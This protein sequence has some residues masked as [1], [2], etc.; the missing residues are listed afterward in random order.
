L[1]YQWVKYV[2]SNASPFSLKLLSGFEFSH[3]GLPIEVSGQKSRALLCV[4]ALNNGKAHLRKYLSELLWEG[5][6]SDQAMTNLRQTL[7]VIK[8]DL[9]PHY[10][11]ALEVTKQTIRLRQDIVAVDALEPALID[12][13]AI[14]DLALFG[15][16][17]A[18]S[19]SFETWLTDQQRNLVKNAMLRTQRAFGQ[20]YELG[21]QS[22][23]LQLALRLH[24]FEPDNEGYGLQAYRLLIAAGDNHKAAAF[25]KDHPDFDFAGMADA[26]P[27]AEK[28]TT[29]EAP[30]ILIGRFNFKPDD[31]AAAHI[32]IAL[33]EAVVGDLAESAWVRV[34]APDLTNL[35]AP[36]FGLVAN[37]PTNIRWNY[38]LDGAIQSDPLT[39]SIW[40]TNGEDQ[41]VVWT[42]KFS[43]KTVGIIADD[44][45]GRVASSLESIVLDAE[46]KRT[47][48][49][50][51]IAG[52]WEDLARARLLFWR[53]SQS[54][55][56]EA[57]TLLAQ[58]L[59]DTPH[60]V[61]VLTLV[62][63]AK[64]MNAWS[65]W[66]GSAGSNLD[67]AARF[68]RRAIQSAPDDAWS[69]MTMGTVLSAR[70]DL[71]GAK[72]KLEQAIAIRPHLAA[73]KG[74][75]ARVLV[76]SGQTKAGAILASEALDASPRDPHASL[77]L[78]SQALAAWMDGHYAHAVDLAELAIEKRSNW[79]PNF[80]IAAAAHVRNGNQNAAEKAI[81]GAMSLGCDTISSDALR[82]GHPF[83]DRLLF[84]QFV[85]NLKAAGWPN[86]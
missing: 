36:M 12:A 6:A 2:Q 42:E 13:L 46:G 32:A 4:L 74:E 84:D 44:I 67:Q 69:L 30:I 53:A 19:L 56:Q 63:Y 66:Q 31:R 34:I 81:T 62:A 45:V 86:T 78:R 61:R 60:D 40:L 25:A 82:C 55:N 14:E 64:L 18:K 21:R 24:T 35:S 79:Y 57:E 22:D 50:R 38:R 10:E 85:A 48:H 5:M 8:R 52:Y 75:L 83:E 7:S 47:T 26:A 23:A 1:Q 16:Q 3:L 41:T 72:R 58:M 15:H 9:G 65:G 80:L 11:V 17:G 27:A 76:F 54:A 33:S 29:N 49:R 39:A 71:I 28:Q 51:T 59:E 73:A 68:S 37:Q 77:W 43:A 20:A 70:L